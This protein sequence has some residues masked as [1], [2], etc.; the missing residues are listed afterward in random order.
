[1]KKS[2]L[3]LALLAALYVQAPSYALAEEVE[4]E[5]AE[6][7]KFSTTLTANEKAAK[8]KAEQK[9]LVIEAITVGGMRSS[10]VAAINM[11]KFANTISDN[12]SAEYVGALP[13]ASIAESLERLAGVT[14]N[15]DQGCSNT[16][17]VRGMGGA[18]TL[19]TLN[20]REIV[21]SFGSRSINLSLFPSA[22]VRRAQV[23]KT[24]RADGLESG[25]SRQVNMENFKPLK[26]DS[27]VATFSA[28]L[29]CIT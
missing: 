3:S 25:I 20:D 17:S 1:M 8:N 6:V 22:A 4:V 11:K 9:K 19:T 13:S 28:P 23:Y 26:V 21:S 16:M 2:K 7:E 12:L 15:Q 29:F 27:N 24:A 18:Y 14:G 10:E 5:K